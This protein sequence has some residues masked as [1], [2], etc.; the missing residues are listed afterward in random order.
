MII[1]KRMFLSVI[2]SNYLTRLTSYC[3]NYKKYKHNS[4]ITVDKTT[5]PIKHTIF[6]LYLPKQ[7]SSNCTLAKQH[8]CNLNVRFD[9]SNTLKSTSF[10]IILQQTL[11]NALEGNENLLTEPLLFSFVL[12]LYQHFILQ[13]TQWESNNLIRM[14]IQVP[15]Q[16]KV[17]QMGILDKF[18]FRAL[19][20][21]GINLSFRFLS[22]FYLQLA[23][24]CNHL[25]KEIWLRHYQTHDAPP[26][27]ETRNQSTKS[28]HLTS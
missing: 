18:V 10:I 19:V 9:H 24:A 27:Q 13:F 16:E 20:F 6:L 14:S 1:I 7:K 22:S 4:Y 26:N 5:A 8:F 12:W 23:F 3:L 25:L 15:K 21:F 2:I 17:D 28:S 11:T